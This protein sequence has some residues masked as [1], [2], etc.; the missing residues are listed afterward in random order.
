MLRVCSLREFTATSIGRSTRSEDSQQVAT[1]SALGA[2]RAIIGSVS[3]SARC[4]FITVATSNEPGATYTLPS[5]LFPSSRNLVMRNLVRQP[6]G[7]Q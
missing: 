7:A 6:G 4:R 3:P 5:A 2:L 1:F